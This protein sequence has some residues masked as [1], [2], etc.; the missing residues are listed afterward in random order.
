MKYKSRVL[1]QI[2]IY[3]SVLATF[4]KIWSLLWANRPN[5]IGKRFDRDYVSFTKLFTFDFG[6]W[7]RVK[8]EEEQV[9]LTF[10]GRLQQQIVLPRMGVH[11]QLPVAHQRSA[12]QCGVRLYRCAVRDK[13]KHKLAAT[14]YL[15]PSEA[16]CLSRG[17]NRPPI[18]LLFLAFAREKTRG[19][20]ERDDERRPRSVREREEEAGRRRE[21]EK[22]RARDRAREERGRG[23]IPEKERERERTGMSERKKKKRAG[24]T[25][26]GATW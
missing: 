1:K 24:D 6:A 23:M 10:L 5:L 3:P 13:Q 11:L 18:P 2:F 26:Q 19:A 9:E 15:V 7:T 21:V 17:I 8:R 4:G 16:A 22:A 12:A 25:T 14:P 20:S